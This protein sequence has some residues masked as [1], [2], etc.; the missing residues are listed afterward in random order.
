MLQQTPRANSTSTNLCILNF[1][2]LK[3][4]NKQNSQ[5]LFQLKN[6]FKIDRSF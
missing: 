3:A 1:E 6:V 4:K 5:E 2:S